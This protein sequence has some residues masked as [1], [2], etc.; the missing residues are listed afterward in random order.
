MNFSNFASLD[1]DQALKALN[2][3]AGGLSSAE[4][5]ERL[6]TYGSNALENREIKWWQ[7]LLGQFNTPFIYLLFGAGAL[8]IFLREYSDAAVVFIFIAINALLGF[9]NEYHSHKSL[10]LLKKYIVSR[11]RVVRGG[12]EVIIES[13]DLVPGDIVIIN[14]GDIIP[15][16]MRFIKTS[17]LSVDESILTGE[18]APADKSDN[19]VKEAEIPVYKAGNIGFSGTTAISGKG[20][21]VVFATGKDS[22]IGEISKLTVETYRESTFEK[23]ISKFSKF[24]LRMIVLVVAMLL[25]VN[26]ALKGGKSNLFELLLFSVALAVTVVPEALPVIT[27]IALS[28]GAIKLAKDSV[29]VKRLSAVE[30]LGSV[31]I[32]CTDKTGTLTENKLT[33]SDVWGADKDSIIFSAVLGNGIV[34]TGEESLN[35]FDIA[36]SAGLSESGHKK[37][38]E[39]KKLDEVPFDPIRKRHTT[40]VESCKKCSL[41][42]RGAAETVFGLCSGISDG[43]ASKMKEWISQ[44]GALGKRVIAIATKEIKDAEGCNIPKEEK[45]LKFLGL[46]SFIDPVKKTAKETLAQ[47]EKLGVKIKILTG[48]SPD[49]A[50][51]VA[52]AVGLI[53]DPS[54]VM[55]GDEFEKIKFLEDRLAA[56]VKFSVF[57]RV[58][59]DQKYK[60]IEVL[61]EKFEVGFLGEG[62][63]DAPALKLA[64]VGIV[65]QNASDLARDSADIVLLEKSLNVIVKGIRDGRIIFENIIKYIKTALSTNFGNFYTVSVAALL[66]PVLPMLPGQ[67]LLLNMLSDFP[68][69]AIAG[70]SVDERELRRPKSYQVREII[71]ISVILGLV[72]T[73]FDFFF[74]VI[75][76]HPA[77]PKILQ[78]NWFIGSILTELVIIFSIRTRRPFWRGSRPSFTLMGLAAAAAMAA[79]I[80]PF[81]ILGQKVFGFMLPDMRHIFLV[82]GIVLAYFAVSETVK[83]FYYRRKLN[84]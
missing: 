24:M 68:M 53:G 44:M 19:A 64:N 26:L 52:H 84:M 79:L 76:N 65:V 27:T 43:E 46:V 16:D 81:T 20:I 72:S 23:N 77:N 49:V 21:G 35:S 13:K 55:T 66:I 2:A 61:R 71:F 1:N 38:S 31:E 7:I 18:S 63:N 47:A 37:L 83:I 4:A 34:K 69:I 36:L 60:I 9:N 45:D 25:L 22:E 51:A 29:V 54:E 82:L 41:V 70:D 57:A 39:Y 32:L 48:D 67:L 40:L 12:D 5:L 73:I 6:K 80:L 50:G 75:F 17:A 10:E 74:F 58:T 42:V 3:G 56:A 14:A 62:I 11:S 33:V 8:S 30:D 15:A 28:R 59:P 78:T